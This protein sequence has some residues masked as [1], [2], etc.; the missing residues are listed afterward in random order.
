M[1]VLYILFG[2]C[3]FIPA[4]L[5]II[6]LFD[7]K[8]RG[9]LSFLDLFLDGWSKF[10]VYLSLFLVFIYFVFL[11][12]CGFFYWLGRQKDLYQ[13][14]RIGDKIKALPTVAHVIRCL[15]ESYGLLS[16]FAALG[17]YIIC[18]VL[19]IFAGFKPL[20][21]IEAGDFFR[22]FFLGLLGI[23]V[24][25]IALFLHSYLVILI[26]HGISEMILIKTSIANNVS[27]I[28]DIHRATLMQEEV[29]TEGSA[30]LKAEGA[31]AVPHIPTCDEVPGDTLGTPNEQ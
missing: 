24:L 6:S 20:G 10:I 16:F 11:G 13:T 5:V 25:A 22:F 3:A 9:V 4:L 18:Y 23:P 27:D 7:E 12:I 15:G 1:K 17:A 30:T 8:T 29:A 19:S 26:A 14:V 21:A 31:V 28:G 2:L